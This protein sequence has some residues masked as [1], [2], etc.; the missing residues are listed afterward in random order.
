MNSDI[1]NNDRINYFN[2]KH[3]CEK[4]R[5]PD[6]DELIEKGICKE[7]AEADGKN[8][9][10][11]QIRFKR[12]GIIIFKGKI[13]VIFPC[14]YRFNKTDPYDDVQ[15]LLKLFDIVKEKISRNIYE[16]VDIEYEGE[17]DSLVLASKIIED[18]K[19]NGCI[20][21]EHIVEGTNV[22]GKVN[23]KKTMRLKT[24]VFNDE[25]MPIFT[26]LVKRHKEND[27]DSLL[28][29]LHMYVVNKSISE[30]GIIWGLK[31]NVDNE[32]IQLPV[33]KEYALYF[34]QSQKIVTYNSRILRVINLIIEFINCDEKDNKDNSFMSFSTKTFYTI[35]ELIC[36]ELFRDEFV[37]MKH[38]M[39]KPYWKI[40][41]K[42]DETNQIPDIVYK[43]ED[44][45]YILDAKY[46]C[47]ENSLPGWH[48]LVKQ[49]FYE[50]SLRDL[51]KDAKSRYNV[52]LIPSDMEEENMKFLGVSG[53]NGIPNFGQ[54]GGILV[55]AKKA[56]KDYCYGNDV[57]YRDSL[58]EIVN[59]MELDNVK[60]ISK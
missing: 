17:A 29:D 14:G 7:Y 10:D 26:E 28:K 27:K 40:G 57:D 25:G 55:N 39:P 8:N 56:I 30:F 36:K 12:T 23:W 21:T 38:L 42:M 45:L 1:N 9:S 53:V 18:Y 54:V 51:I 6:V 58:R 11:I 24:Q 59:H 48:D 16:S 41:N 13:Y 49:F 15:L 47:I 19:E 20:N 50:M 33:E 5:I 44:D 22:R 34:L 37:N 60:Y 2:E 31:S 46:Y 32:N 4:S 3:S 52:M 35:W 43:D